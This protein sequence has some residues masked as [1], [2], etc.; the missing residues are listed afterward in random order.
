VTSLR[1]AAHGLDLK[2]VDDPELAGTTFRGGDASASTKLNPSELPSVRQGMRVSRYAV[3]L[4]VLP[5]TPTIEAIRETLRRY[6]NQSMRGGA[7]VS[8]GQRGARSPANAGRSQGE[9]TAR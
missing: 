4:G 5:D 1:G 2:T 3:V 7:I 6:R 9:R 8:L